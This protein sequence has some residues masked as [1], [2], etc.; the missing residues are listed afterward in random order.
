V[1]TYYPFVPGNSTPFTFQPTFDGATY[2]CSVEWLISGQRWYVRC[3]DSNGIPVFFL[4]L[5]GSSDPVQIQAL[6]W[7]LGEVTVTT[8]NELPWAVGKTLELTVSGATAPG[9]NGIFE[10]LVTSPL[11]IKYPLDSYPGSVS[12]SGSIGFNINIAGGYFK[13]S[14]LIYRENSQTFEVSP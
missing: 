8:D 12:Q 5:I 6:T 13:T 1:T 14:T 4:P 10:C 2:T 7:G 11:T 3:V 9:Y